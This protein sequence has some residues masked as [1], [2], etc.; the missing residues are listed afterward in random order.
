MQQL[1]PSSS[2]LPQL[3]KLWTVSIRREIWP[4]MGTKPPHKSPWET[5]I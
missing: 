5:S 2:W 4:V 1:V 3:A